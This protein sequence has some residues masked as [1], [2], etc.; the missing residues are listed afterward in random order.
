[1]SGPNPKHGQ[2]VESNTGENLLATSGPPPKHGS[3]AAAVSGPNA[4]GAA[5]A[6]AVPAIDSAVEPDSGPQGFDV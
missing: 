1:M 2:A 3:V 5:E 6:G 4:L